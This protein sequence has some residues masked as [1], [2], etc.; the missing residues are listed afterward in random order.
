M[1]VRS[2]LL[3]LLLNLTGVM[4][5]RLKKNDDIEIPEDPKSPNYGLLPK[6]TNV[7]IEIPENFKRSMH[8]GLASKLKNDETEKPEDFERSIY[9]GLVSKLKNVEY[10]IP[11]NFKRS[12][13]N[14]LASKLRNDETEKPEEPEP[15]ENTKDLGRPGL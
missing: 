10:E 12:I 2:A 15:T 9:K 14:G 13:H 4:M 8:N 6:L 5:F 3:F 11:E 1:S 7:E